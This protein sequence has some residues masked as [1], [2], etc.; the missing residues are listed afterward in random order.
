MQI[1]ML[2]Y[3][4]AT[5]L[6]VVGPEPMSCPPT[7]SRMCRTH[8]TGGSIMSDEDARQMRLHATCRRD[9]AARALYRAELAVHDAHES[10][11]DAWI[12][13]ANDHL[14]EAVVEYLS[15]DAALSSLRCSP[16]AA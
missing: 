7:Q 14:H 16:R 13:A 3:P 12:R 5:A 2:L 8:C 4:G 10:H 11:V 15:A 1:A 6:D 9:L